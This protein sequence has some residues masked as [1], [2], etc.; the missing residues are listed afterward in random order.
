MI[1]L[2]QAGVALALLIGLPVMLGPPETT[3]GMIVVGVAG[4]LLVA[5]M[6]EGLLRFLRGRKPRVFHDS[7]IPQQPRDPEETLTR[8]KPKEP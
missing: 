2:L 1:A 4:L 8:G 7:V 5:F 3:A 6:L